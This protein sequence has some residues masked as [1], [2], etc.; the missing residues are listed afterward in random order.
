MIYPKP[1]SI[2]LRG[3]I[4][5]ASRD[6][7][8][9]Q[10]LL[11]RSQGPIKRRRNKKVWAIVLSTRRNPFASENPQTLNPTPSKFFHLPLGHSF[12]PK[13]LSAKELRT[14]RHCAVTEDGVHPEFSSGTGSIQ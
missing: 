12:K 5:L 11:I 8:G 4:D 6:G 10:A 7:S 9:S 3:I 2:Y 14:W 13:D 1:Y